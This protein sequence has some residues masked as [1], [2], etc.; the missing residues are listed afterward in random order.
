[1]V[2]APEK[3]SPTGAACYGWGETRLH[4]QRHRP[5]GIPLTKESGKASAHQRSVALGQQ[6]ALTISHTRAASRNAQLRRVS[7]CAL[8]RGYSHRLGR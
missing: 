4:K 7:L 8:E 2:T 5:E 3:L 6:H 1:M